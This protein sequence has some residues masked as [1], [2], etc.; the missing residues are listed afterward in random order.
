MP[1]TMPIPIAVTTNSRL[2]PVPAAASAVLS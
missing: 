1:I 2:F